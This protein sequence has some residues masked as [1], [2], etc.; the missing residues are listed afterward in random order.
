MKS[1]IRR[2][3]DA[4]E[5]GGLAWPRLRD[6]MD[7]LFQNFLA[8]P[9]GFGESAAGWGPDVE[10]KETEREIQVRAEIPGMDPADIQ[11]SVQGNMLT[12]SGEKREEREEEKRDF[13]VSEIRYGAFHRSVELPEGADPERVSAEYDKGVLRVKIAK[14]ESAAPKRIAVKG[15]S[16][17]GKKEDGE[18]PPPSV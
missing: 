14:S 8:E 7:R 1:P 2:R 17:G 9:F 4:A 5:S 10:I 18:G 3:P 6:R 15:A 16:G 13:Y 11:L 12:I